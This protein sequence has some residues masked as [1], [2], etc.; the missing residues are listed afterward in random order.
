MTAI[1]NAEN[2]HYKSTFFL[3]AE[4]IQALVQGLTLLEVKNM[5]PCFKQ[6]G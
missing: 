1:T 6:T 3:I 2:L 5:F 4:Q